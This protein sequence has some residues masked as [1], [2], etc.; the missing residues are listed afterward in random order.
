MTQ[1][2]SEQYDSAVAAIRS[3][4]SRECYNDPE[5]TDSIKTLHDIIPKN[6]D[7]GKTDNRNYRICELIQDLREA[8]VL[9]LLAAHASAGKNLEEALAKAERISGAT[10]YRLPPPRNAQMLK[11]YTLKTR[12]GA[13]VPTPSS[14]RVLT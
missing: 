10:I 14:T 2:F 3:M 4:I 12:C 13:A 9:E 5:F 1:G 11:E 6:F 7:G 8:V